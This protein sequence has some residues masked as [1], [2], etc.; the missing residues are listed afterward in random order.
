MD[1]SLE[2]QRN[3][4]KWSNIL[5][6]YKDVKSNL[7]HIRLE[8]PSILINWTSPFPILG[9]SGVLFHFYSILNRY[10]C[11]ANSE[12]PDQTPRSAASDLG[13]HCLPRSPK[14]DARLIWVNIA[15]HMSRLSCF[16]MISFS[17]LIQL[18][19]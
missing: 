5:Q 19:L 17:E 14:R 8:D 12:D 7:T 9:V 11:L 2:I 18:R 16:Q 1:G 13:L 4:R 15:G 6:V 3:S 10:F